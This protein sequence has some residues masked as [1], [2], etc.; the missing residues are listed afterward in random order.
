MEMCSKRHYFG[1]KKNRFDVYFG[2]KRLKNWHLQRNVVSAYPVEESKHEVQVKSKNYYFSN[3]SEMMI[4]SQLF[5]ALIST[6]Y[7]LHLCTCIFTCSKVSVS[8]VL[9]G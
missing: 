6:C 8:K 9:F 7:S 1:G 2:D 3:Q 5:R 4:T